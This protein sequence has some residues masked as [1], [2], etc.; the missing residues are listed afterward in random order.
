[1]AGQPS[2]LIAL[3]AK[4]DTAGDLF[5]TYSDHVGPNGATTGTF[6]VD[7]RWQGTWRVRDRA[8]V[9]EPFTELSR[10]D[11]DALAAEA[12][13]LAAFLGLRRS[14]DGPARAG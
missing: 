2:G 13:R 5:I 7:G 10:A 8:V 9:L 14:V 4:L 1:M 6:L 3:Q 12:E 11:H